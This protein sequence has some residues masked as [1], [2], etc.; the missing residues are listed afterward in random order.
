MHSSTP[1][2]VNLLRSASSTTSTSTRSPRSEHRLSRKFCSTRHKCPSMCNLV[3]LRGWRRAPYL[4]RQSSTLA[5]LHGPCDGEHC[6]TARLR[7][8]YAASSSTTTTNLLVAS[9]RLSHLPLVSP[10]QWPRSV[11]FAFAPDIAWRSMCLW[12]L[13]TLGDVE[14]G[15]LSQYGPSRL[16][17]WAWTGT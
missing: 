3:A 6:Y 8:L 13:W 16:R 9:L 1:L 7:R 5:S 10:R 2:P 11:A 17:T 14:H 15:A 12:T 4:V